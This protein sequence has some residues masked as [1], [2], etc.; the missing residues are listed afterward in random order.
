M[1]FVGRLGTQRQPTL[2][3]PSAS[4]LGYDMHDDEI[5]GKGIGG[6]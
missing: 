1:V 2:T 6:H 4:C 5:L 3:P